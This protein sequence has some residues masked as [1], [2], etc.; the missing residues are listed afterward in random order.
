MLIIIPN[1]LL[2]MDL[3]NAILDPATT[4]QEEGSPV[5]FQNLTLASPPIYLTQSSDSE[6]V[7][8]AVKE[9]M[10]VQV[11]WVASLSNGPSLWQMMLE[12]NSK[13]DKFRTDINDIK[14]DLIS[15]RDFKA[16]ACLVDSFLHEQGFSPLECGPKK[17]WVQSNIN[18]LSEASRISLANIMEFM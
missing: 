9:P 3:A 14:R 7:G 18:K 12:M 1:A 15:W 10:S 8:S 2:N 16:P 17:A 6:M 4:A 13:F 11:S 5:A